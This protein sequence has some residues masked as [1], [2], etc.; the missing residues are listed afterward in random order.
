[1]LIVWERRGFEAASKGE[2]GEAGAGASTPPLSGWLCLAIA[3]NA[4]RID[5]V[6][7]FERVSVVF[8]RAPFEKKAR[9]GSEGVSFEALDETTGTRAP[10]SCGG[11]RRRVKTR[12][13]ARFTIILKK[14]TP[15]ELTRPSV[16]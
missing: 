15:P 7:L 12:S 5:T 9:R 4:A 10:N 3:A 8:S 11:K 2:E 14:D 13:A 16:A 1:M 6:D